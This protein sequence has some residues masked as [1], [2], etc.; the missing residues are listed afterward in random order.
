[1][2]EK[3]IPHTNKKYSI[4]SD[5]IVYSNYKNNNQG[6]KFYHKRPVAKYLQQGCAVVNLQFGKWSSTN[7]PKA[8]YVTTLMKDIFKLKKPDMFHMYDLKTKN[9]NELDNSLNNLEWKIRCSNINFYPQPKY[10]KKGNIISKCCSNCGEIKDISHYTLQ[11]PKQE[12]QHKTYKNKCTKCRTKERRIAINNNE[13]LLKRAKEQARRFTNSERG[14]AYYK[15]YEKAW[16]KK[17]YNEISDHYISNCLKIL[18]GDI[19]PELRELYKKRI[20]LKRKLENH[21]KE[22]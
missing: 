11:N 1:M 9:G 13:E 5:G 19:T 15:E 6:G 10:D 21:G 14:K 16:R 7:K 3:F 22:N 17:N 18:V 20:T 4:T 8:T 12:G 2:K